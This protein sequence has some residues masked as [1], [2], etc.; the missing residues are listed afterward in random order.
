MRG[1]VTSPFVGYET[2]RSHVGACPPPPS[3]RWLARLVHR[4]QV[5]DQRLRVRAEV[6]D[7][8]LSGLFLG[9][10][11]AM[12]YAALCRLAPRTRSVSCGFAV[13]SSVDVRSHWAA[14][15]MPHAA[16]LLNRVA[17]GQGVVISSSVETKGQVECDGGNA[18]R[19]QL[20]PEAPTVPGVG[21]ARFCSSGRGHA[22][23]GAA[24]LV[25]G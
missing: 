10:C 3:K 8:R 11:S 4:A 1:A 6:E 25:G 19:R 2:R 9:T 16:A 5:P 23:R 24:L 22:L 12:P 17:A 18:D 20:T 15:G 13:E 21:E 7:Q 14:W